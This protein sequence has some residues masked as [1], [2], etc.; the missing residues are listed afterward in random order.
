MEI[1]I[2]RHTQVEIPDGICFGQTDVALRHNWKEDLA[3][4]QIDNDYNTIYTSPLN[5]CVQLAVHFSLAYRKD[6]RL[7]EMNFGDW[8]MK[9]WDDIPAG[10]IEPWYNDF[11]HTTPPGGENLLMLRERVSDFFEEVQQKHTDDKILVIT[12]SGVMRLFLQKV[13][14]FPLRNMFRIQ[15]KYGKRIIMKKNA[16]IWKIEG[17]NC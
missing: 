16:G 15:P 5:R 14:E 7:I 3:T 2:I 11:V 9:N 6:A 1:H 10:E 12:H 17:I 8:E 4:V 13:L